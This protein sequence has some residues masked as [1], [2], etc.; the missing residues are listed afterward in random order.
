MT[1]K[2]QYT[3]IQNIMNL[4]LPEFTERKYLELLRVSNS[5]LITLFWEI[6]NILKEYDFE[7][8]NRTLFFT[9]K[10]ISSTYGSFFSEKNLNMMHLF[11]CQF[12]D[13]SSVGQI[14]TLVS[15][16]HIKLLLKVDGFETKLLYIKFIVERGL[17]VANLRKEIV[18]GQF[19]NSTDFNSIK[20]NTLLSTFLTSGKF[21]TLFKSSL[22]W[23]V[24]NKLKT[25]KN[26]KSHFSPSFI[27]LMKSS[28]RN[29]IFTKTNHTAH[30]DLLIKLSAHI[31]NYKE[32][33]N[34][35]LN[36]YFNLFF[37]EIGNQINQDM[38]QNKNSQ[39]HRNQVFQNTSILLKKFGSNF[40]K[41]GLRKIAKFT[42]QFNDF[43]VA[44]RIA[45]LISWKHIITLLPLP[46]VEQKLFYAR[47][48][49]T[50]GLSV[51][52]LKS[53]IAKNAYEHT[54]G[55]KEREKKTIFA[56]K[57]PTIETTVQKERNATIII[58]TKYV[59]SEEEINEKLNVT[60]IF[61]NPYFINFITSF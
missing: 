26:F 24:A 4:D 13:R 60:N 37:W 29:L 3:D 38:L 55:A 35:W 28:K 10:K 11:A 17:T 50:K 19:E 33:H 2:K 46:E 15:W 9:A 14:S 36:M 49:A 41:S 57:N 25:K 18:A 5:S 56:L 51:A 44:S 30:S 32:S 12:A 7:T 39:A 16:N 34:G 8:K 22:T 58:T 27:A 20:N 43:N 52:A 31:I 1:T 61:K 48:S 59:D 47:L 21:L 45:D 54:S 40:S 42:E 53:Q 6:G 23:S